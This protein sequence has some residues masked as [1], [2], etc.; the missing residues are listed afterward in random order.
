MGRLN[1]PIV[2]CLDAD[3]EIA[4]VIA[5]Q[6]GAEHAPVEREVFPDGERYQRLTVPVSDRDVLLVGALHSDTATLA[7]FD[8]ACAAVK[9]GARRLDLIV[10]YF[11]YSTME[12]ATRPGEIVTAKYRARLLSAIPMAAVG[13][14]IWMVDLHADGLPHYMEDHLVAHHVYA[15]PAL[16]PVMRELGGEGMV[17]ASPD[18][19]RA[20]WVQSLAIE[21]G[22]EAGIVIKRRLSGSE[23]TVSTVSCDVAGRAVVIYDDMIRTGGSLIGAAQ[24]YR[25][26]GAARISVVATHGVLPGDSLQRLRNSGLFEV[27]ATTDTHPQAR[28]LAADGLRLIPI[29]PLLADAIAE[30]GF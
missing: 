29:A 2:I 27:I 11:G 30:G 17:L 12:R 18:A 26:A 15:K 3:S 24:T 23:T 20:K 1:D 22:C 16:L 28:A 6:L 14:R 25:D 4:A 13:N 19:G 10:P 9:Y 5:K 7:L 21:I 8:L